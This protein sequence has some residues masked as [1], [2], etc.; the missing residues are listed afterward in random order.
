MRG[1]QLFKFVVIA[2][3]IAIAGMNFGCT[4]KPGKDELSKLEEAKSAS[5]SAEKK[6]A[7]LK[8]ERQRL[9]GDLQQRQEELKKNEDERDNIKQ[10]LGK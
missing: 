8:Q 1:F 4:K 9:E 3:V 5:E 6:L 7:E 2:A 10:K